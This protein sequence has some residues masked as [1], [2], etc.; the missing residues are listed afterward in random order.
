MARRRCRRAT[1]LEVA[2][3]DVDVEPDAGLG[4]GAPGD[5]RRR[6]GPRRRRLD[7]G[8]LAIDL[9]R[10]VAEHRVEPSVATGTR[11]GWATHVPSKPSPAFALLVV[12]HLGQRPGGDLG[13]AAVGDERGHAADG[14]GAALVARLH[15]QLGVGPHERAR[16][17]HVARS[18]R[19]NWRVVP[20]LLDDREDVV[21]PAGVEPGGVLAQLV[22]D[23]VHLERGE[24][25]LD[26]HG[27]PDRAAGDAERVLRGDEDVVPEPGLEVALEL[28]QVEVG[29]GAAVRGRAGVVEEDQPEVEEAA[30]TSGRRR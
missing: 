4:D 7:V 5:R 15:Q 29:A 14:V 8:P 25:R 26:E 3:A 30:P 19:T 23:L 11:S 9:V 24:D 22:E 20:E 10:A 27:G 28:G 16:H 2:Q 17:R 1:R 6:A 18:G 12:A 13:V 21:P